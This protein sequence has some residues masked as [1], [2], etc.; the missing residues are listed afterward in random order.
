MTTTTRW[1]VR[2]LDHSR[3][4]DENEHTDWTRGSYATKE[5]AEVEAAKFNKASDDIGFREHAVV[6]EI[7]IGKALELA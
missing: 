3:F 1:R 5:E 6:E 4:Q 2:M 7:E